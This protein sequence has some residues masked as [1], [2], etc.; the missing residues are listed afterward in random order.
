MSSVDAT[1]TACPHRKNPS[2]PE[3]APKIELAESPSSMGG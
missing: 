2:T 1:L 3:A